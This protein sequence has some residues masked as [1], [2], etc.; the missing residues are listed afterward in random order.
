MNVTS[1]IKFNLL[2]E[3]VGV[4]SPSQGIIFVEGLTLRGP[5]NDPSEIITSPKRFRALFGDTNIASLFPVICMG[6]LE[7][8]AYLRVNRIATGT[9]VTA[10]ATA[11]TDGAIPVFQILAKYPGVDYNNI[12]VTVGDATNGDAN[13]FNLTVEHLV[14]TTMV[15]KYENLKIPGV[16]TVAGSEYL[17]KVT[18]NSSLVTVVYSDLS[19]QTAPIR[20]DN[21]NKT[22]STGSDGSTPAVADYIGTKA[23]QTG[24]YAFDP[25]DDS[26]ALVCPAVSEGDLEG[27]TAGGDS[28]A[29]NRQ[30]L[31]Y[32]A[33][34]GLDNISTTALLA[35]K[36]AINNMYTMITSGG[37]YQTH[38]TSGEVIE[39]PEIG[40]A[41]ARM[42][43]VHREYGEWY[44][45]FGPS[46]GD[47]SGT[48]GAVNNFGSSALLADL[49]LLAQR[50]INMMVTRNGLTYL[51]DAYTSEVDE[52]PVNHVSIVN[53]I[54]FIKKSLKPTL[55]RFIGLPL[56]FTL[57]QSIFYTVK[58][59]FDSL[60]AGR[61]LFDYAW[62]GDQYASS[63]SD[64]Q[65]N[66]PIDFGMG[67]YKVNLRIIP[68][69]PLKEITINIIL[70]SAGVE[71]TTNN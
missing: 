64:L 23:L 34:L 25:Y 11:F 44:S 1:Q 27:L 31:V 62:E 5:I 10:T 30:D 53:L 14:D 2:N 36:P 4:S 3:A 12:K 35:E 26:Y 24:F 60:V 7:R 68:I 71:L 56:D 20:P 6:M 29:D 61:A 8:G 58:P 32:Y 33:H 65:V 42:A 52:S 43:K 28:Y 16:P 50:Q 41:L 15:E 57:I 9:P 70:T 63:L 38:P 51:A 69:S 49:N 19:A 67:R 18:A 40:Y 17:K 13:S 21:A 59:L 45:F 37:L 47:I 46:L 39:I 22:L 48:L 54:L 55:E 66:D